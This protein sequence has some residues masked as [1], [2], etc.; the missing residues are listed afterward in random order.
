MVERADEPTSLAAAQMAL[1]GLIPAPHA[2]DPAKGRISLTIS[3]T[4]AEIVLD[5]PRARHALT[6]SMMCDLGEAV[7]RVAEA[8]LTTLVLRSSTPDAFCSGGHLDDV[9]RALWSPEAGR[10]MAMAMGTILDTLR[11][12]PIISV[13]AIAGP[14]VGGGAELAT[15]CDFRLLSPASSI[16]F[17]QARLGVA[18]GWGGARRLV[19]IVGRN[20]ALHLLAEARPIPAAQ[21]VALGLADGV[22]DDPVTAAYRFLEAFDG[23]PSASLQAVKSQIVAAGDADRSREAA[24]FASVWSGPDHAAALHRLSRRG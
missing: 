20:R 9:Q 2:E 12:L 22:D 23:V 5:H 7:A 16:H 21:A 8:P 14:A 6:V 4:R 18:P 19:D 10:T 17:V 3:G 24:I 15:A 11:S 13:A 1:R